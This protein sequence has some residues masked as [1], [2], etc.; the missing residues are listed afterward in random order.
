MSFKIDILY[1]NRNFTPNHNV[2]NIRINARKLSAKKRKKK[3]SP[4]F[5]IPVSLKLT[6]QDCNP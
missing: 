5:L 3:K 1:I 2:P 4:N 6:H